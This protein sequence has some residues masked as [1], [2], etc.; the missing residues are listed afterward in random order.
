MASEILMGES[1]HGKP[2]DICSLGLVLWDIIHE[3]VPFADLSPPQIIA[4][5]AFKQKQETN[6]SYFCWV[7]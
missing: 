3:K 7:S 2:A 1:Q 5:V 4:Q 6:D